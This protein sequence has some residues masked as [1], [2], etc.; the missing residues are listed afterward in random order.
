MIIKFAGK[1]YKQTNIIE[2]HIMQSVLSFFKYHIDDQPDEK[3]KASEKGPEII[4]GEGRSLEHYLQNDVPQPDKL[5]SALKKTDKSK[6]SAEL[7]IVTDI[8]RTWLIENEEDIAKHIA[9]YTNKVSIPLSCVAVYEHL[10]DSDDRTALDWYFI[11]D[12]Q[13]K[14]NHAYKN[15]KLSFIQAEP[16]ADFPLNVKFYLSAVHDC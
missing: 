12:I 11:K 16:E 4:D 8:I 6:N 13:E 9:E 3:L 10:Y 1:L 14:I 15:V 5:K 7:I 2:C